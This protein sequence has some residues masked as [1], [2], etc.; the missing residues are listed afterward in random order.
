[1]QIVTVRKNTL[2]RYSIFTIILAVALGITAF[3]QTIKPKMTE[4]NI[5]FVDA[6]LLR[7]IPAKTQIHH[8]STQKMAQSVINELLNGRDD[9]PSIKRIIPNVKNGIK[10]KV[11]DKVAYVD[12]SKEVVEKHPDGRDIELLTV[13]SI[14]N[15]LTNI[16][17]IVNVR[18]TIDGERQKDFKG[19]LDMRE[20]FIPD[21][22]I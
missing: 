22:F 16:E 1:M 6:K 20:T 5:Y 9:N 8:T 13:Y 17:G 3:S 14:V 4:V 2:I 11:I 12:I 15:S 7:L 21:Y 10:V 19:Y 18:F